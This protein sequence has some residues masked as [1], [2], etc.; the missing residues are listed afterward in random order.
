DG[1]GARRRLSRRPR[2]GCRRA[3]RPP[4]EETRPASR[5]RARRE[6]WRAPTRDRAG[7][8]RARPPAGAPPGRAA[9]LPATI[10]R[11]RP[12]VACLLIHLIDHHIAIG[13][14]GAQHA[15]VFERLEL[16]HRPGAQGDTVAR[17]D[18]AGALQR[19]DVH[20]LDAVF[21]QEGRR[22]RRVLGAPEG[23]DIL[24][25]AADLVAVGL[26][27]AVALLALMPELD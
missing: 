13:I 24:L 23:L 7:A 1:G 8:K 17:L 26:L 2:H 18:V 3:R 4:K 20:Q 12:S 9:P 6:A 22:R 19:A 21:A 14:D 5:R 11:A 25:A 10:R 16:G 15:L 27:A